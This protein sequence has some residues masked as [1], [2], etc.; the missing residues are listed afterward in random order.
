MSGISSDQERELRID[1]MRADLALK[2][3]QNFW[4]AWKA[5]AMILLAAAA[6]SATSHFADWISPPRPQTITVHLDGLT[7]GTKP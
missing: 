2:N 4:E 3:R 5:V 1:L 7:L 6:I